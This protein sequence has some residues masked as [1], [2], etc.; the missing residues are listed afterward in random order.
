M[1]KEENSIERLLDVDDDQPVT[2][3]DQNDNPIRFE[4]HALIP[5]EEKLYAI[6]KPIDKIDGVDDDQGIIFRFDEDEKGEPQLVV[7]NDDKII[8][9]VFGIYLKMI[10]EEEAPKAEPKKKTTL[11]KQPKTE[12]KTA[13]KK[14]PAKTGTKK[15]T[16]SSK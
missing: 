4:Q 2:L 15:T 9:E 8:D 16:K 3:Y 13:A 7:I 14:A 10:N 6:L 5:F 12:T 1:S 11:K